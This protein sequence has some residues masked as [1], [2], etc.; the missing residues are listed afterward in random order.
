ME[1]PNLMEERPRTEGELGYLLR[2]MH[3]KRG[4]RLA[5]E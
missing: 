4:H 1:P 5:R 3:Q 2:S